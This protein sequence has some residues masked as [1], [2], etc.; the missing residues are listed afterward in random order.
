MLVDWENGFYYNRKIIEIVFLKF[1]NII[2]VILL[3]IGK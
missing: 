2:C 3:I 1:Y